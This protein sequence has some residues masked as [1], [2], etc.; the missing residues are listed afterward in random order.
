MKRPGCASWPRSSSSR[1][2]RC[3][4]RGAGA[5]GAVDLYHDTVARAARDVLGPVP[6]REAHGRLADRLIG[7]ATPSDAR[8]V[9]HLAGAGRDDEAAGHAPDAA[10][11]AEA[12]KAYGL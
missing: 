12:L 9:R 10:R 8:L 2:G 1:S 11:H 6:V 7:A 4:M 3:T 5:F